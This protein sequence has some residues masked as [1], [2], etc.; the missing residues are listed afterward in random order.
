MAATTCR[1]LLRG[2]LLLIVFVILQ[3]AEAAMFNEPINPKE[4]RARGDVA[5]DQPLFRSASRWM[6][7]AS[8]EAWV[9]QQ[10]REGGSSDTRAHQ[11]P[12]ASVEQGMPLAEHQTSQETEQANVRASN[13]EQR[14]LRPGRAY[15][16]TDQEG[17]NN[18]DSTTSVQLQQQQGQQKQAEDSFLDEVIKSVKLGGPGVGGA[19]LRPVVLSD[20]GGPVLNPAGTLAS[21]NATKLYNVSNAQKVVGDEHPMELGK[22]KIRPAHV[23]LSTNDTLQLE[24]FVG[25]NTHASVS[26]TLNDRVLLEVDE[27]KIQTIDYK[28]VK[29]MVSSI[30]IRNVLKLPT[31]KEIYVF[32]CI[33]LFDDEMQTAQAVVHARVTDD[34]QT[35]QECA[36]RNARCVNSRCTCASTQYPVKLQSVHTTCRVEAFLETECLYDEQC[37]NVEPK[38]ECTVHHWCACIHGYARDAWSN[39]LPK[40]AGLRTR[41]NSDRDCADLGANC[42]LSH[43]TCLGDLEERG[44]KCV[45]KTKPSDELLRRSLV[46]KVTQNVA[47]TQYAAAFALSSTVAATLA[48][49]FLLRLLTPE[50]V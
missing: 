28:G 18:N 14:H 5:V 46:A 19:A 29:V 50:S 7:G 17:T 10:A 39:C 30:L 41:C 44:G 20:Q 42:V 31:F 16:I 27:S 12:S 26:W 11:Q 48:H 35:D 25:Y 40:S 45:A 23:V 34:C 32:K 47:S 1:L 49:C 43:C 6:T 9:H 3:E 38:S 2:T 21:G 4:L 22:V 33:Y 36:P 37:E 24:C 13:S 8:N 15:V